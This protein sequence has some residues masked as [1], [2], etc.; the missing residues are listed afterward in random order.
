MKKKDVSKKLEINKET[1][2]RLNENGMNDVK[3]GMWTGPQIT[4]LTVCNGIDYKSFCY[5]ES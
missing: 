2:A 4:C 3:G 5:C 1:I